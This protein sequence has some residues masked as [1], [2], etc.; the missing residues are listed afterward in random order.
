MKNHWLQLY[1]KKK[2][3]IWT[4][5]FST[6]GVFV[7]KPRTVNIIDPKYS[8][9][10]LGQNH[11]SVSVIFK[12]AMLAVGDRELLN[13]LS[14]AHRYGLSG[15]SSCLRMYQGLSEV[16]NYQLSGLSYSGITG[17]QVDDIKFNFDFKHVRHFH[18]S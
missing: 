15:Y 11:G 17:I 7:L 10:I 14:E 4:A 9:G 8:L 13:F 6:N 12:D 2:R 5:E 16:E 18:V 1:E 3:K